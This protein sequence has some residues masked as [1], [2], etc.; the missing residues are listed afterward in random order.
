MSR[1]YNTKHSFLQKFVDYE[2]P[3]GF[4]NHCGEE[5]KPGEVITYD[6]SYTTCS[7]N[8]C[9]IIHNTSCRHPNKRK[10]RGSLGREFTKLGMSSMR[11]WRNRFGEENDKSSRLRLIKREMNQTRRHRIKKETKDII[12]KEILEK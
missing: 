9:N 4:V 11:Y 10:K 5:I 6:P 1:T 7:D 8:E 2:F 12:N 3:N